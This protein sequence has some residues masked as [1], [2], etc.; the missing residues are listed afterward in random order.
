MCAGLEGKPLSTQGRRESLI[1][2]ASQKQ[3]FLP[4]AAMTSSTRSTDMKIVPESQGCS[5]RSK[6]DYSISLTYSCVLQYF[7]LLNRSLLGDLLSHDWL[8]KFMGTGA[9][10][11]LFSSWGAIPLGFQAGIISLISQLGSSSSPN[12]KASSS[13]LLP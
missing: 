11:H 10:I 7:F 6:E 8:Q 3:G 1:L 12:L 2:A 4:V 5:R 9:W 13:P